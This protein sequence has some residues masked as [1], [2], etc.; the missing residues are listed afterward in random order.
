MCSRSTYCTALSALSLLRSPQM[1]TSALCAMC[2]IVGRA[3][4]KIF[5]LSQATA[6]SCNI[7]RY[8]LQIHHRLG[9]RFYIGL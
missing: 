2:P 9:A 3:G 7:A 8:E 6:V 5:D 1:L 4:Q